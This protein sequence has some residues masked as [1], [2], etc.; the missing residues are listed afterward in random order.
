MKFED[1]CT[2]GDPPAYD[3]SSIAPEGELLRLAYP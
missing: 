2:P 3:L 1:F